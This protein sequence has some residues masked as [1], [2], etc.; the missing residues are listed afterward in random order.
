MYVENRATKAERIKCLSKREHSE[1][2][3][4]ESISLVLL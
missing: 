3:S 2:I 4:D 1:C